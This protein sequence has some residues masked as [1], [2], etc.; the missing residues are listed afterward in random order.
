MDSTFGNSWILAKQNKLYY[1]KDVPLFHKTINGMVVYKPKGVR[2]PKDKIDN[3]KIPKYLYVRYQDRLRAFEEVNEAYKREISEVLDKGDIFEIQRNVKEIA[4]EIF[5]DPRRGTALLSKGVVSAIT[6]RCLQDNKTLDIFKRFKETDYTT[7]VH[8][9]HVM[10][11]AIQYGIH[12]EYEEGELDSISMSALLHDIGKAYIPDHILYAPRELT[13]A[14]FDKMKEHPKNGYDVLWELGLKRPAKVAL[15]HHERNDKT[16]Y[17]Y[18]LEKSQIDKDSQLIAI[19]DAYE[20]MTSDN[21]L[22]RL[23]KSPYEALK[24]LRKEVDEGKFD[25][26]I[27]SDFA[28]SLVNIR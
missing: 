11:L 15:K 27:F 3:Q 1:Y 7:I 12:K 6:K 5:E 17:P 24:T 20:S 18:G 23:A 21:R 4:E 16:G 19:I 26:E 10:S 8:S 14:E 9:V 25:F 22:Y 28:R 2:I 13:I